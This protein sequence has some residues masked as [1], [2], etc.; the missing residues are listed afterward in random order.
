MFQVIICAK[1]TYLSNHNTA[2]ANTIRSLQDF[3]SLCPNG[4]ITKHRLRLKKK[5]YCYH[6][7]GF[8][9]NMSQSLFIHLPKYFKL[10]RL[11]SLSLKKKG[12]IHLFFVLCCFVFKN[13][14]LILYFSYCWWLSAPHTIR[15]QIISQSRLRYWTKISQLNTHFE[16]FI[17]YTHLYFFSVQIRFS[18]S[19]SP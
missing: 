8:I 16:A 13:S 6:F 14:R 12:T 17:K 10:K 7:L 2:A 9:I 11:C 19:K 15:T 18:W 5:V 1:S 3:T 4:F